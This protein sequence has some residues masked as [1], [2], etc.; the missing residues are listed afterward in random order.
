MEN[1][2]KPEDYKLLY[3][4]YYSSG[5]FSDGSYLVKHVR[6]LPEKLEKRKEIAYYLNYV[7]PVT[8]SHVDPVFLGETQRDWGGSGTAADLWGQFQ[9][10]CD[11]QGTDFRGFMKGAG[12]AAKLFG[13]AFLVMDNAPEV[14]PLHQQAKEARVF[15]YVYSVI[16]QSVRKLETDSS[17]RITRFEYTTG[18]EG[19][20]SWSWTPEMW[21]AT[22]NGEARQG[23]NALGVVPVVPLLSR[24]TVDKTLFPTPEFLPIA[25]ANLR[26]YN[27]CSEEDEILRNQAFS[28]LTYPDTEIADLTIGTNNALG[29]PKDSPHSPAFIAPPSDPATLIKAK[30]DQLIKE[31][32]RMAMLTHV[33]GVDSGSGVAK[34]WDF[35]RTSQALADFAG[36]C[37]EAERKLS[38]LFGLYTRSD[39]SYVVKYPDDYGIADVIQILQEITMGIDLQS[40]G[41]FDWALRKR[42]AKILLADIPEED[43]DAVMADLDQRKD[44]EARGRA[45]PAKGL[46]EGDEP[47]G[48]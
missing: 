32:Y 44:D 19:K 27:L 15:P 20:D 37:E 3:D 46:E 16:P 45:A 5:G 14:P 6:E 48:E 34:A 38:N 31:I 12:L 40:G 25:R 8:N 30:I 13:V 21:K 4:A 33:T 7:A 47:P 43:Y 11:K 17:G 29:Y 24:K 10:D 9:K 39:L 23:I 28:I 42:A 1:K 26:I 18:P 22:V 35:R 41:L 36:N 2:N